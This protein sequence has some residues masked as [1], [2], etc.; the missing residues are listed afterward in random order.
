MRRRVGMGMAVGLLLA[1]A[2][3]VGAAVMP[4]NAPGS[5]A[6]LC[7]QGSVTLRSLVRVDAGDVGCDGQNGTISLMSRASVSGAVAA[8][9]VRL[10]SKASVGQLFCTTQLDATSMACQ[11]M[12]VPLI[13][14]AELPTFTANPG[15]GAVRVLPRSSMGPVAA[16]SYGDVVV[17]DRGDLTLSGGEYQFR[18]ISLGKHSRLTCQNACQIIVAERI[19]MKEFAEL[20]G[21][22]ARNVQVDIRGGGSRAAFRAF[23]RSTVNATV[24][25]PNG[26]VVLGESGH[27]TGAFI[28]STVFVYQKAQIIAAS[29]LSK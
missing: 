24:F 6:V 21:L 16:A 7:L 9:H 17:G 29:A 28:G 11:P 18:S 12:S 2:V 22:D 10:G 23:R 14:Q 19:S 1:G 15:Q 13:N 4:S 8:E 25:A 27:Y 5:Y 26:E 20:G 3:G